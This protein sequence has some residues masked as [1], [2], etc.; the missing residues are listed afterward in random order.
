MSVAAAPASASV[1]APARE[2]D[3]VIV[4]AGFAGLGM[5]AALRER[6]L[7]DFVVLEAAAGLGGTWRDNVY[8]GA[9][10]DVQSVLYSFSFAQHP[11]W[12]REFA[13]QA[14]ILAYMEEVAAARGLTPH[15]RYG[16]RVTSAR[17][18]EA[19]GRWELETACGERYAA[20]ALVTA[21]GGLS[22]PREPDIPG[23][24]EF[25]GPRFHTARW[26]T[27]ADL[28]GR[29]GVI[30]TGASAIQVVPELAPSARALS[31]FQR[32]PP[33]IVPRADRARGAFSRGLWRWCPPL[34]RLARW[35]TYWRLESRVVA[36]ALQPSL[37]RLVERVARQHLREQVPDPELRARLTPDYVIGCK[38]IL[39][40]DDY[41][42]ALQ[43]ENV[44]L[45]TEAIERITPRGV[46]TAD[47]RERELD[48]LVL[49]TG[50]HA[51]DAMAP[52]PLLGRGGRSLD[53]A[54]RAG[55]AAYKGT[56]VSGFPNLFL[57]VGPNTGLGH[58]SMILM[59]ES[60]VAYAAGAIRRLLARDLLLLDVRPDVQ[61]RYNER[62]QARL[63]GT[64]WASGCQSWYRSASG[65][66]TTLWPGFT[67][68]F[69]LRTRRFDA[70]SY[71]E[72]PR[73]AR[74]AAEERTV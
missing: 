19:R 22:R 59:I 50:F 49:A 48:A 16:R 18:D 21:T 30:G 17:F 28:S 38:R 9:A 31:L 5:A 23:L 74:R 25:E 46:R 26:E 51:A 65:Q 34:Q 15:L 14:E 35:L 24:A 66:N 29:I 47:G 53:E 43:R 69:R 27:G 62:L 67:F 72:V 32:T 11:G 52:F 73:G 64:V 54:W 37:M 3:V 8:P 36:F 55:A 70:G 6:G 10:C 40:S 57:L 58:S 13:P 45:V 2:L 44:E 56:T 12:T 20:R 68:E 41:Y 7:E 33:W 42:P 63:A 4:G 1:A 39:L 71:E 61:A 60:Q